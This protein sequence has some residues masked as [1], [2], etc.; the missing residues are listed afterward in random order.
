MK[1]IAKRLGSQ[2]YKEV[3]DIFDDAFGIQERDG[4]LEAYKPWVEYLLREYYDP[5]YD[6]QI[7]KRSDQVVFRGSPDEVED[8][9]RGN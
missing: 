6:Y 7:E 5:M 2:R 3:T 8:Y 1:R 4:S 9:L